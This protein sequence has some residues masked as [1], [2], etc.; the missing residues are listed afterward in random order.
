MTTIPAQPTLI[1]S[2][3]MPAEWAP[4]ERCL[5]AWPTRT[6]AALWGEHLTAA[7]GE[8]AAV[9]QAIA[10][11]EPVLM[12]VQLGEAAEAARWLGPGIE[13]VELPIDDSWMRDSGPI[14]VTAPSGERAG[15]DFRF[16]S[17]GERFL[18]YDAD[19]CI[20]ER[21]LAHVGETRHDAPLVLEGGALT[22][23][24]EGTLITTEQCL[25]H[26]NRN[27]T[28]TRAQIEE[29]LR[30]YLGVTTII[31]LPY[32]QYEDSQTDGHVDGVCAF[33]RP[34]V[35]LL[36]TTTDTLHPSYTRLQANR[37][38]LSAA[39]DAAGRSLEVI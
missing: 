39:R 9:A 14:F 2:L 30:H 38:R 28:L 6:R 15:V 25:L 26:P 3:R 34:G 29:H 18:P 13:V 1:P 5:M 16:N 32:G 17:W 24:G 11:F 22:V 8:Y 4:H 19:A 36:Q 27:P 35:V 37:A 21:L 10:A 33:I 23:D 12:V 31:W 7:Y 20:T